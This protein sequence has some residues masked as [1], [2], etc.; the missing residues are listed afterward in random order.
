MSRNILELKS[1]KVAPEKVC[2]LA[3]AKKIAK[4]KGFD[5]KEEFFEMVYHPADLIKHSVYYQAA[6]TYNDNVRLIDIKGSTHPSYYG[7]NWL[8]MMMSLQRHTEDFDVEA[9]RAAILNIKCFEPIQLSKYGDIYFIDG[10]GNHRV[11]QAKFLEI[12]TVPCEVTEWKMTI[13]PYF[14]IEEMVFSPNNLGPDCD[15]IAQQMWRY[16]ADYISPSLV[17]NDY[18]EALSNFTCLLY[19]LTNHF[20]EDEH[21]RFF[22]DCYSPN[23]ALQDIGDKIISFIR[24]KAIPYEEI[25][26]LE[27]VLKEIEQTE[28]YRNYGIPST[29]LLKDLRNTKVFLER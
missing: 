12:E 10:G 25:A 23:Y 6:N 1:I 2:T 29:T 14:F 11:C 24:S 16:Y 26:G 17:K 9:V 27:A 18:S 20:V 3:A 21:W 22:D 8:S 7:L 13:T 28:A 5:L 15:M 4:L 19:G